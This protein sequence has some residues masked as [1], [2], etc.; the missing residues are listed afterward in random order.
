M[1]TIETYRQRLTEAAERAGPDKATA[2]QI[3]AGELRAAHRQAIKDRDRAAA[4]LHYHH[5]WTFTALCTA[6]HGR[7]NKVAAVRKAVELAGKPPRQAAAKAEDTFRHAQGDVEQLWALYKEAK[8]LEEAANGVGEADV[9]LDLPAD[10][11]ARAKAAAEQLRKISDEY[12]RTVEARNRGAAA[13]TVHAGWANRSAANLAGMAVRDV[14]PH[15]DT[16]KKAEADPDRVAELAAKTR[17]L[18]ARRKALTAAR[19]DAIRALSATMGPAEIARLVGV[20]DERVVQV[21]DVE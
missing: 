21:R 13:L 19:D 17:Q 1:T 9:T 8:A 20:T 2:A 5:G 3:L 18:Q 6:I 4:G 14:Y 10:P 15:Q 12:R 16:A 7:P 11:K